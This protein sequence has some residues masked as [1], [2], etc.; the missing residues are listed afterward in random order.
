MTSTETKAIVGGSSGKP[1]STRTSRENS[2]SDGNG[3]G[4]G[5]GKRNRRP[6]L[7]AVEAFANA[8]TLEEFGT[9]YGTAFKANS[10]TK[11]SA[12]VKAAPHTPA[13]VAALPLPSASSAELRD[14]RGSSDIELHD[15][16]AALQSNRAP[17]AVAAVGAA[18]SP[19]RR[20]SH[21]HGHGGPP[22]SEQPSDDNK[23]HSGNH[24]HRRS[25]HRSSRR[26]RSRSSSASSSSDR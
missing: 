2:D 11:S 12:A 16:D 20:P 22:I 9:R 17:K 1:S 26:T 4:S 18:S 3:D 23:Q 21:G 10:A 14:I 5:R 15:F 6:S 25:R 13:I 7:E 8:M 19:H 24:G